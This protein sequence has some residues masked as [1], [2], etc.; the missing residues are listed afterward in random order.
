MGSILIIIGIKLRY[1]GRF[2]ISEVFTYPNFQAKFCLKSHSQCPKLTTTSIL[3]ASNPIHPV[4]SK[5]EAKTSSHVTPS[6]PSY[7]IS[8]ISQVRYLRRGGG[9]S[10]HVDIS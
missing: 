2:V 4:K 3:S 9:W 6:A 5:K 8:V 7:K 10:L 1:E